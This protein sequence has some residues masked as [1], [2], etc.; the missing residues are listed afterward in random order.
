MEILISYLVLGFG[1]SFLFLV[2]MEHMHI[3]EPL[4]IVLLVPLLAV[5]WPVVI[6]YLIVRGLGR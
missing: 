5:A 6:L 4:P 2:I 1:L 3:E